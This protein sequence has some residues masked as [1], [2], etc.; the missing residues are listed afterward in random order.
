MALE[1]DAAR[2][3]AHASLK[4][5]GGLAMVGGLGYLVVLLIHGDLPDQ[6]TEAALEHIAGRSEWALLTLSL[7]AFVLCWVGA[8]RLLAGSL[9]TPISRVLGRLAAGFIV[10]G[11]ALVLVEY[12]VLGYGVKSIANLWATATGTQP[13]TP[14]LVGQALLG[15]SGGLFLSFVMWLIGLPFLLMGLAI[16]F[17]AGYPSWLGWVAITAG[18]GALFT[19]AT[20]FLSVEI[21]PFPVLYGAFVIPLTLWL[22]V[23]GA[24][25][26]RQAG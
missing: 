12:S 20:R 5:G 16:A 6:T 17:D 25:M 15:V 26:W 21:V 1:A 14:L 9:S 24:L 3:E 4:V 7:M 18:A 22:A 2:S 10:I 11:A 13:E 23:V 8:F 19:G